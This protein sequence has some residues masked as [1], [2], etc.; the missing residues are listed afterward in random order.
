MYLLR[1]DGSRDGGPFL[2]ASICSGQTCTP[3]LENG[4]AAKGGEEINMAKLEAA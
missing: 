1:S 4:Q 2:V 3:S